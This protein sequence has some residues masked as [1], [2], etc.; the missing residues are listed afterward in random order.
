MNKHTKID[1]K[2]NA[3]TFKG[4]VT[5]SLSFAS[6]N[7]DRQK[8]F[9]VQPG[10]PAWDALSE[11]SCTLHSV[12]GVLNDADMENLFISPNQA[13]LLCRAVESAKAAI[14]SVHQGLEA[15]A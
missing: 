11:A 3:G 15:F 2:L 8:L 6:C 4:P 7:V 13:S 12:R 9:A 14:D 1:G 5:V 10:I